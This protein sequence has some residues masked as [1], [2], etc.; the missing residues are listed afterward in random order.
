MLVLVIVE[1]LI[2]GFGDFFVPPASPMS[3]AYI[4]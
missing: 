2:K 4:D 3:W 1:I